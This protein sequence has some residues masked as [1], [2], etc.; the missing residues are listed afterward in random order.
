MIGKISLNVEGVIVVLVPL[1]I[2][3]LELFFSHSPF[4]TR[5]GPI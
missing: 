5:K 4:F 1:A 2:V 3:F